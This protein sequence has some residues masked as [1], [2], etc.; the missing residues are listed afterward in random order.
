MV[1]GSYPDCSCLLVWGHAGG[2]LAGGGHA[3]GDLAG[4]GHAGGDLAGG[5]HAGGDLAGRGCYDHQ[6]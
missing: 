3:G 5:S 2:G 6:N 1:V 4:G